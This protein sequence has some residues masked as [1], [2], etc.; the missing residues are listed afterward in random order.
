MNFIKREICTLRPMES[1]SSKIMGPL[2]DGYEECDK[3]I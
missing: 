2:K 1:I 3:D